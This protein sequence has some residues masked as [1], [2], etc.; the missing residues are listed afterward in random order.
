MIPKGYSMYSIDTCSIIELN[1][2]P[3]DIFESLHKD[4]D[5]LVNMNKIVASE[6][7]SLELNKSGSKNNKSANWINSHKSIIR[8]L[9]DY[10][11]EL[12]KIY[13]LHPGFVN[14]NALVEEADN[15]V[16]ALAIKNG[17]DSIVIT[18]ENKNGYNK[19]PYKCD[20]LGIKS[21]KFLDMLRSLNL[22][23]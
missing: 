17:N 18:E 7:V 22:K 9:H 4:I 21:I 1:K 19:I 2:F 16:I 13:K 12:I 14:Q 5:K 10:E 20:L 15:H 8:K 23:Y 3:E 6:F 11:F